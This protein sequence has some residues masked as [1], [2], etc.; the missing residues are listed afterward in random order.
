MLALVRVCA[1]APE[2]IRVWHEDRFQRVNGIGG[3]ILQIVDLLIVA[4]Q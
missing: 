2:E 1:D 4:P 3:E